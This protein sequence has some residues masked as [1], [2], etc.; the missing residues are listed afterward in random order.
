MAGYA[1]VGGSGMLKQP[2]LSWRTQTIRERTRNIIVFV[3]KCVLEYV[4]GCI[5]MELWAREI[6]FIIYVVIE[7]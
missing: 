7:F 2:S 6:C 1:G 4:D 3:C 5:I